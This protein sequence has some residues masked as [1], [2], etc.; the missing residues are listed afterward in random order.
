VAAG[1]G[2]VIAVVS[3]AALRRFETRML[4][5]GAAEHGEVLFPSQDAGGE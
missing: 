2:G 4:E 1:I 5:A 3:F